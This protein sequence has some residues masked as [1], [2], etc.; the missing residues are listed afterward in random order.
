[1]KRFLIALG[2]V[3]GCS[4]LPT[5]ARTPELDIMAISSVWHGSYG[6][7]DDPPPVEF[8]EKAECDVDGYN[9]L[10]LENYGQVGNTACVRGYTISSWTTTKPFTATEQSVRM[11]YVDMYSRSPLAHEL[12]H[13]LVAR[14]TDYTGDAGHTDPRF[15]DGTEHHAEA[16]LRREG[17]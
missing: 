5:L 15:H 7:T 1:M 9:G 10:V 11:L 6:R 14:T 2:L 16:D 13:V 4:D 17:M 3:A 12:V 8:V